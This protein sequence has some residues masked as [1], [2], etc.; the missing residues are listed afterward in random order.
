[1]SSYHDTIVAKR[2]RPAYTLPP[3]PFEPAP[4]TSS[5]TAST[6][7]GSSSS[8]PAAKVAAAPVSTNAQAPPRI[9]PL[10][11]PPSD[12]TRYAR[13]WQRSSIIYR[14]ASRALSI[15]GYVELLVEMLARKKGD[16]ARWRVVVFFEAVK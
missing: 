14:K 9:S 7:G 8:T 10:L 1:V 5:S 13:Y 16:R 2:I 3:H 11:P 4:A 6:L 15:L 12:H